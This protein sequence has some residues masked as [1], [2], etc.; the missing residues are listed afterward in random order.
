MKHVITNFKSTFCI[1]ALST[2]LFITGCK[3][4][5]S[6]TTPAKPAADVTALTEFLSKTTG[7][8]K[9]N[10]S[11]DEQK[12]LF[13]ANGDILINKDEL[14]KHYDKQPAGGVTTE[15]Y[16]GTY[17]VSNSIITEV[18]VNNRV[19]NTAW[20]NAV[21]TAIGNWNASNISSVSKLRF[22]FASTGAHITITD[23]SNEPSNW[24]ARAYLPT[25][26]GRPGAT[27][28]IN[29]YHDGLS[30]SQ[31]V[32]ALTHELGH[33]IGL[34]H[35]NQNQGVFIQGTPASDP[36]SVMNSTVLPWSTFTSG[37]ITAIRIL[38]PR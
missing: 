38:Y 36:N 29:R 3:R 25:S 6:E 27:V 24:I 34:L 12:Q 18:R 19:S 23:L 22:V 11:Y 4:E 33:N 32:F 15:H 8:D 14:Q 35:T 20:S 17:L 13:T 30:Q 21:V 16:R 9:S 26:N 7:A 28:E 10:I 5:A 2:A 1:A 31:K 37:D